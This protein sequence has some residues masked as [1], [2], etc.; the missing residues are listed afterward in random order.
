MFSLPFLVVEMFYVIV[1]VIVFFMVET[2]LT[3]VC[4]CVRK[5]CGLVH[6]TC[7]YQQDMQLAMSMVVW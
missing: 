3:L 5:R 6:F 1:L 4:V 7:A 2:Y